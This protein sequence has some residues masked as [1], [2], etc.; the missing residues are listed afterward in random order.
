MK[1]SL[2]Y[3]GYS[4]TVAYSDSDEAFFG[5][6]NGIRD[7]VTFEAD[8]VVKLKKAFRE[9][10]DD[11]IETCAK[12]GKKTPIKNLTEVLMVRIKSKIHRLAVIKSASLNV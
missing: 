12:L 3:K 5:K 11:Y 1:N 10:V 9:A 2:E 8:S 7:V 4:G 6:I